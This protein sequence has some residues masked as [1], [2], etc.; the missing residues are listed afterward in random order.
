MSSYEKNTQR[1][2]ADDGLT[3]ARVGYIYNIPQ[4]VAGKTCRMAVSDDQKYFYPAGMS[5]SQNIL[6][7]GD[8]MW[9]LELEQEQEHP[10][11]EKIR[12]YL[13]KQLT[14]CSIDEQVRKDT[15]TREG[16]QKELDEAR[17]H[18]FWVTPTPPE[19]G[20]P[21]VPGDRPRRLTEDEI[22]DKARRPRRTKPLSF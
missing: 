13:I 12:L 6:D 14:E 16:R 22:R 19:Y 8:E 3:E 17:M 2:L 5:P 18:N 1:K 7:V 21:T 11:V 20:Y 4:D 9:G 15:Q 10:N